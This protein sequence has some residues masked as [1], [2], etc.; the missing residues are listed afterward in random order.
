MK[1]GRMNMTHWRTAGVAALMC[2][3][4]LANAHTNVA[5]TSPKNGAVLERSP[6]TIEIKF[7]QPVRMTSIV[8]LA[9]AGQPERKLQFSPTGNAST[10]TV[11]DPALAPGR[12]EIQWKALSRDGHVV[13][14][15]LIVVV[16]AATS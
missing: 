6:P 12:N 11:T 9:A 10:F 13:S 14:G 2:F 4:A 8:V 16:K 15:S 3:A 1:R 7:E 5:S